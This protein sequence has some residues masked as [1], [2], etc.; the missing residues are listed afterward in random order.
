MAED[1]V[2]PPALFNHCMAIYQTMREEATL[3]DVAPLNDEN[4][5]EGLI[6]EGFLTKLFSDVG[7]AV[8]YYSKV[9]RTLKRM[10]CVVQLRRGGSSTPSRWQLITEPTME[11]FEAS[12]SVAQHTEHVRESDRKSRLEAVEDLVAVTVTR[13]NS[14]D[15]KADE[16]LELAKALDAKLDRLI[17]LNDLFS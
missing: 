10:G 15:R 7:L 11:T 16:F 14:A 3:G 13:A 9:M 6:Y 12:E 8:P 1:E 4:F 2:V 17:E 5:E